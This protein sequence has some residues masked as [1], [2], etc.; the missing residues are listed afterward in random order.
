M[1]YRRYLPFWL[2]GLLGW[3]ALYVSI[4][5]AGREG[6][7]VATR[8]VGTGGTLA[9]LAVSGIALYVV[10]RRRAMGSGDG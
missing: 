2:L 8:W 10:R 3:V 1:S 6:W 9:F 4:G 5:F 7:A